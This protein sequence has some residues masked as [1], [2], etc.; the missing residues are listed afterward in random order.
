MTGTFGKWQALSANAAASTVERMD[1]MTKMFTY[2]LIMFI[3]IINY[4]TSSHILVKN[5]SIIALLEGKLL[6]ITESI[7]YMQFKT[8]RPET[9]WVVRLTVIGTWLMVGS[10]DPHASEGLTLLFFLVL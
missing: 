3:L 9:D 10:T 2:E 6:N 8:T 7:F 5:E 1:I 4:E